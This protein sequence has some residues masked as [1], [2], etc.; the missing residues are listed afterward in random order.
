MKTVDFLDVTLDLSS[1]AFRPYKKPNDR[2][3]YVHMSSNHPRNILKQLPTSINNR[4]TMNSSNEAKAEY[5]EALRNSGYS[6]PNL[7]FRKQ[8]SSKTTRRNRKRNIIWF[9][10]PFSKNVATNVA[11]SFLRLI[12]KHFTTENNLRKVFN[13]NCIKVSYSCTENV[14]SIINSHNKKVSSQSAS[15]SLPCNC[16]NKENC[17]LTGNCRIQSVVYKCEVTAPSQPKRVYIG[18]TEKEFKQR[19]N[20]H[21]QSFK[22]NKYKNST[23]LSTYIWSLKDQ[24][25]TPTINWSI[26]KRV[27]SYSNTTK[28]CP[29]CLQEKLEILCYNNKPELLNKRTEIVAKCRH[30]NKFSLSKCKSRE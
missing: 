1:E 9:N 25:I 7:V 4:L 8:T 28:S 21:N 29:L 23:T 11:R 18:L 12:A 24:N 20:G 27:K 19:F 16:R 14:G 26:V 15:P 13:K 22:N 6:N 2:L 17:P 3:Q 10:L 5:E 30:M